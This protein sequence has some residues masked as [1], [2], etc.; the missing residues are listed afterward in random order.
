M[1]PVAGNVSCRGDSCDR[2][3]IFAASGMSQFG[4]ICDLRES[5]GAVS[6]FRRPQAH[7]PREMGLASLT[8]LRALETSGDCP[9]CQLVAEACE[10]MLWI[11]LW[12][13]VNDVGM[14]ASIR[15]ALGFCPG[16]TLHLCQVANAEGLGMTG[17]AIIF[18]DVLKAI[19][20]LLQRHRSS[21]M[22][23]HPC[24]I[25][26]HEQEIAQAALHTWLQDVNHPSLRPLIR[27]RGLCQ[28]HYCVACT[29]PT[30]GEAQALVQTYQEAHLARR[31]RLLV[32]DGSRALAAAGAAVLR[33]EAPWPPARS[34]DS[35]NL[36]RST[37]QQAV[38][39][40][41]MLRDELSCAICMALV[42][43]NQ[44]QHQA[45]VNALR[46]GGPE[47]AAFVAA[48]GVCCGHAGALDGLTTEA[49][50]E[51]Y[52]ATWAAARATLATTPK[53]PRVWRGRCQSPEM[54]LLPCPSCAEDE[55][56]AHAMAE[57]QACSTAAEGM[58]CCLPHLRLVLQAVPRDRAPTFRARQAHR[59]G[60]LAA[61]ID[62]MVRKSDWQYRHGAASNGLGH[63]E[64]PSSPGHC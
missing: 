23:E 49:V 44:T 40:V 4:S 22:P 60:T 35:V 19:Q 57:E 7:K 55:R 41:M 47:R 27:E 17:P 48:G 16:H 13:S 3:R 26:A 50:R 8:L 43:L 39:M 45:W 12:E 38:H 61:T 11:L 14:R 21:L 10:G 31:A 20:M 51:L 2:P 46:A 15:R 24:P 34:P 63:M 52:A 56:Y 9:V 54:T 42:K 28:P 58:P 6:V 33:G 1:R 32:M 37:A 18:A 62:E 59:L 29:L 64:P 36:R 30:R 53:R 5:Q 25:C